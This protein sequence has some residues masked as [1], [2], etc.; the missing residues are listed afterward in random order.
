VRLR[1]LG[2]AAAMLALVSAG[3]LAGALLAPAASRAP[4]AGAGAAAAAAGGDAYAW[5]PASAHSSVVANALAREVAV[6]KEPGDATPWHTYTNPTPQRTPLVFLVR[7]MRPRWVQV[8]LPTR[9]NGSVGWLRAQAVVLRADHYSVTVDLA[10]RRLRLRR[11]VRTVL[12]AAIG[13]GRA[14]TPTPTGLYY[15]TELLRQPDPQGT[16]GPWAFALSAHS[17][18]LSHFGGGDGQIGLHGTNDPAGV[19]HTVS[20]GCIRVRND[21]ISR[22][23]AIVPLGTP[24]RVIG[25]ARVFTRA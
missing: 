14:A 7:R 22:L 23:A 3:L 13:V 16:Y 24:V 25:R 21:V 6:Y 17:T 1:R 2:A 18:V 10:H 8:M 12:R 19:G 5:P 20:H 11:G 15:V 9:P 4:G